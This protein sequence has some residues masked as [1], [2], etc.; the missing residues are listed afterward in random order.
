M[1]LA[2]RIVRR[3]ALFTLVP[4]TARN[5]TAVLLSPQAALQLL[6]LTAACHA[7]AIPLKL[8]VGQAD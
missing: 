8:V 1:S 7:Q 3:L 5:V 6:H 4:N 2:L